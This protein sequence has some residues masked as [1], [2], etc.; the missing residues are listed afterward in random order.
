MLNFPTQGGRTTPKSYTYPN[1]K[2]KQGL[3]SSIFSRKLQNFL[4]QVGMKTR[5]LIN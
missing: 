2:L 4:L 5:K 1:E 3:K